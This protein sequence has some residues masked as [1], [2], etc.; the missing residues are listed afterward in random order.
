MRPVIAETYLLADF[1]TGGVDWSWFS[2]NVVLSL[3]HLAWMLTLIGTLTWVA[4]QWTG[5]NNSH[6]I[7][8]VH[9]AGLFAITIAI[10][11]AAYLGNGTANRIQPNFAS[12]VM[13]NGGSIALL[14]GESS[15][16]ERISPEVRDADNTVARDTIGENR[17]FRAKS[18]RLDLEERFVIADQRVDRSEAK[19]LAGPTSSS[20]GFALLPGTFVELPV[21]LGKWIRAAAPWLVLAYVCGLIGMVMRLMRSV[22]QCRRLIRTAVPIDEGGLCGLL[23]DLAGRFG[24]RRLP[25]LAASNRVSCPVLIGCWRPLIVLPVALVSGMT[26]AQWEPILL[27]EL[28]HLRRF[29]HWV[30]LWQRVTESLLFFHPAVWMIS[31]QLDLHREHCCD[32]LVIQLGPSRLSTPM[33]S[34][35]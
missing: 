21:G 14:S 23:K 20:N 22:C 31:R 34:V 32:D 16:G 5:R 18:D 13:A 10:P 19:S 29:D 6:R 26:P 35:Q 3:L 1:S 11:A 17:G 30:V 2:V 27:H 8:F 25:L 4:S 15:Q 28:A 33:H 9:I 24:C 7:Y 12:S